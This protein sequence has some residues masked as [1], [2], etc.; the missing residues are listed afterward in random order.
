MRFFLILLSFQFWSSFA[1]VKTNAEIEYQFLVDA[2]I[3]SSMN[4]SLFINNN[5]SIYQQK[6]STLRIGLPGS[7]SD[8]SGL[9][10][11]SIIFEPYMKIDHSKKEILFF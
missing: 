1:Q 11:P 6:A 2:D 5:V 3:T 10:G 4:C 8:D 9:I 7:G